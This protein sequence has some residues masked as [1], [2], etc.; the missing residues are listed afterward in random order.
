V[1]WVE[2]NFCWVCDIVHWYPSN[3]IGNSSLRPVTRGARPSAC[4]P[5]LVAPPPCR[6]A[7]VKGGRGDTELGVGAV[8]RPSPV[9]EGGREGGCGETAEEWSAP[10]EE[11]ERQWIMVGH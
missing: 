10:E 9:I 11:V 3:W 5:G 7:A 1:N 8:G 2:V 6:Q 4:R